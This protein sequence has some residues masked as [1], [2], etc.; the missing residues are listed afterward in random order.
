LNNI[1]YKKHTELDDYLA[2]G[3]P[4]RQLIN[5]A[6][7]G[8]LKSLMV[9]ELLSSKVEEFVLE[10]TGDPYIKWLRE[11]AG[12]EQQQQNSTT[13]ATKNGDDDE[14]ERPYFAIVIERKMEKMK[15]R[16]QQPYYNDDEMWDDEKG[17]LLSKYQ[18]QQQTNNNNTDTLTITVG[19][20][21]EVSVPK[22]NVATQSRIPLRIIN[23]NNNHS[24]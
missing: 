11:Q 17:E 13:P 20:T 14:E 5:K 4:A 15:M 21:V 12:K 3:R 19:D 9:D 16:K 18:Q 24:C 7:T 10:G 8:L 23:N 1:S 6:F 22:T 2:I